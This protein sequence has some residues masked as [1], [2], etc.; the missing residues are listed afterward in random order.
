MRWLKKIFGRSP[1]PTLPPLDRV[2]FK[3]QLFR[4]FHPYALI[5]RL[6]SGFITIIL[7]TSIFLNGL[8]L[9]LAFSP[10]TDLG[11]LGVTRTFFAY[12]YG[13]S[14]VRSIAVNLTRDCYD[15]TTCSFYK[16]VNYMGDFDYSVDGNINSRLYPSEQIIKDKA[17]ECEN[18]A[19]T[20]ANLYSEVGGIV[21]IRCNDCH[22]WNEVIL[23][24]DLWN[25]S[26]DDRYIFDATSGRVFAYDEWIIKEMDMLCHS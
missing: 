22:C 9:Y 4:E 25:H 20:F 15:D 7:V 14:E 16:I 21:A 8:F 12:Q 19:M 3:Y 1:P 6:L 24:D 11:I 10:H 13:G 2:S 5:P 17:G 23:S 18:L 26:E